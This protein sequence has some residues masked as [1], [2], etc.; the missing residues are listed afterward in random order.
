MVGKRSEHYPLTLYPILSVLL[1][2]LDRGEERERERNKV[3]KSDE[4]LAVVP[5]PGGKNLKEFVVA[6]GESIQFRA[7][8]RN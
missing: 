8:S 3:L 4:I 7:K 2:A 5:S 6:S 1:A